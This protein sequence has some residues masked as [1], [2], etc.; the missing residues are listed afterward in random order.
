MNSKIEKVSDTCKASLLKMPDVVMEEVLKKLDFRSIFR[1]R[2][3]CRDLRSSIDKINPEL[4]LEYIK[5]ELPLTT[6]SMESNLRHMPES[7]KKV[8]L[9]LNKPTTGCIL[10]WKQEDINKRVQ[11]PMKEAETLLKNKKLILGTLIIDLHF[12]IQTTMESIEKKEENVKMF[13]GTMDSLLKNESYLLKTKEI[14]LEVHNLSEAAI[15][16]KCIDPK[17]L[18]TISIVYL[19]PCSAMDFSELQSLDQWKNAEEL[20]I[21]GNFILSPIESFSTFKTITFSPNEIE[22]DELNAVKEIFA[23][24]SN[25]KA[26]IFESNKNCSFWGMKDEL[27]KTFGNFDS[28]NEEFTFATAYHLRKGRQRRFKQKTWAWLKDIPGFAEKLQVILNI[29][30]EHY[31]KFSMI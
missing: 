23:H 18:K 2:K 3:V 13:L 9:Q 5:F 8:F 10:E 15:L 28:Y 25:A 22:K 21:N 12:A 4:H 17:S 29:G 24:S 27:I 7:I 19:D 11:I 6:S 20:K 26:V 16:L 1:L 14:F 30:S 31:I